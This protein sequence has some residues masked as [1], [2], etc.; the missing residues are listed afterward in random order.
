MQV[1]GATPCGWGEVR[2]EARDVLSQTKMKQRN[3]EGRKQEE[4]GTKSF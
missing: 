1:C 3:T 2:E 4:G